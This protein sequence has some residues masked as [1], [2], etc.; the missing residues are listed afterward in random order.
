[1]KGKYSDLIDVISY[2]GWSISVWLLVYFQLNAKPLTELIVSLSG[3]LY[4]LDVSYI[5][6]AIKKLQKR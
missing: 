2:I 5:K 4:C 6:T 3:H 1:M